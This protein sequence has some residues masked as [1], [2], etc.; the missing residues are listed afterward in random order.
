[1]SINFQ[2]EALCQEAL[3]R[4]VVVEPHAG[5]VLVVVEETRE[6]KDRELKENEIVGETPTQTQGKANEITPSN[7]KKPC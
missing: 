4:V 2:K 3:K 5:T 6:R 1:M 7:R